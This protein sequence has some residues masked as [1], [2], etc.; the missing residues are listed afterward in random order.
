MFS[1]AEFALLF[2]FVI[3]PKKINKGMVLVC[4]RFNPEGWSSFQMAHS[5]GSANIGLA[6]TLRK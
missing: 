4:I 3:Y 1:K 5:L 2:F 6:F